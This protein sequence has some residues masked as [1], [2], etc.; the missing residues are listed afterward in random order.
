M[1]KR[2]SDGE[3]QTW[4]PDVDVYFQEKACVDTKFSCDWTKKTLKQTIPGNLKFLLF[5]DNLTGQCTDEFK[6]EVSNINGVVWYGLTS[7]TD[8]WQPVNSGYSELLKVRM[9]QQNNRLLDDNNNAER[10]YGNKKPYSAK[11]CRILIF[12]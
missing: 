2:I 6:G 9:T 7:A 11:E 1:G 8:L 4:H 3:V 5:F 12:H 10:W